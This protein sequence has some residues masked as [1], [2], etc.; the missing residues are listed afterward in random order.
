[1]RNLGLRFVRWG[2]GFLMLG[3][4]TGYGP[5]GHYLMGGVKV[6]CPWAPVHGH[7]ASLGWIGMTLFGLVYRALPEWGGDRFST[8]R[9]A[10]WHF[11]LC[12]VGVLGVWA[13]GL[14][15]YRVID[16]LSDGF[17]YVPDTR[18]LNLWLSIDGAFLSIFGLGCVLFLVIVMRTTT[19]TA[20]QAA[21]D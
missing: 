15:G 19:Y 20:E 5:L 4:L 18:M 3:L 6:A 2:A 21:S 8:L 14:I 11:V 7:V 1:M 17:Y 12:V 10:R 16:A 9:V 13:N